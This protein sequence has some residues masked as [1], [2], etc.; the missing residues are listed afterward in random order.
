MSGSEGTPELSVIV[1][2][3]NEGPTLGDSLQRLVAWLTQHGTTWE[4]IF[5][6]DTSRDDSRAVVDRFV[7]AHPDLPLRTAHHETNTGRGG[8]VIDG[9]RLARGRVAGFLD[10]DLE[11]AEHYIG[12]CVD[13]I[14]EGR[15]D[16]ATGLRIYRL[17]LRSLFR[18]VLSRG[19]VALMRAMLRTRLADTE[20]G[21]KWFRREA[22]IPL[23]DQV[24]AKDWFFDT[25][26]MV[27]AERAGLTVLEIPVLFDRRFD[28]VSTVRP[29]H[30]SI[31]YWGNLRRFRKALAREDRARG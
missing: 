14:L 5:I 1:P 29:V 10:I 15:A 27:R 28:K 26:V 13:A 23:L 25:E 24:R 20:S 11:V 3:Y 21:F 18:H 12:P 7:A 8:A 9:L 6:D 2:C 19:Y 17:G 31:V 22:I 30:D 16:V 4:V